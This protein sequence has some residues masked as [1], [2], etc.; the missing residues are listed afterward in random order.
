MKSAILLKICLALGLVSYCL[1]ILVSQD[2]PIFTLAMMGI[3]ALSIILIS[4]GL[5]WRS[6]IN[7]NNNET[8]SQDSENAYVK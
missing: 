1:V 6:W 4:M 5:L 7:S 3:M 2:A 8:Y